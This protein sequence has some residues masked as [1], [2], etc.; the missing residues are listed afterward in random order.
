MTAIVLFHPGYEPARIHVSVSAR[1][2]DAERSAAVLSALREAQPR[3][4]HGGTRRSR[5]VYLPK[6]SDWRG[7]LTD[8]LFD[9]QD[10]FDARPILAAIP[11]LAVLV[12]CVV[13][14]FTAIGG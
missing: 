3:F 13:L 11:A 5:I 1:L 14:L 10:W 9:A 6:L 4:W 12:A 8:F 7:D 2:S